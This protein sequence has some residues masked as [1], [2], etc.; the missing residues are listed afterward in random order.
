MPQ[1]PLFIDPDTG[2][3]DRSQIVTEAAPL[4]GLVALF[5]GLALVPYLIVFLFAGNSVVG[6]IFTVVAQA[7]LAIGTGIVLM[8]VITRSLQLAGE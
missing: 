4:A 7:I 1:T 2:S 3:L 6:A 5:L 8:Y